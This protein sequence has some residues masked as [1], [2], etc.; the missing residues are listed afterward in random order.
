M[1]KLKIA[2]LI[3]SMIVNKISN[4][5]GGEIQSGCK[6]CSVSCEL[7]GIQEDKGGGKAREINVACDAMKI[8]CVSRE[9]WSSNVTKIISKRGC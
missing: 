7:T 9:T 2:F 4:T 8:N 5:E 1:F 3:H 6:D